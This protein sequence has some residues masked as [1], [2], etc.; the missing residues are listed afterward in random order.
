MHGGHEWRDNRV[1]GSVA[2]QSGL[3]EL[4]GTGT[5]AA[6]EN[7]F[8]GTL[9][10]TGFGT[11]DGEFVGKFFGPEAQELGGVF[12]ATFGEDA[13]A[14][15]F[16][17][18]KDEQVSAGT[19]ALADLTVPKELAGIRKDI[20]VTN[21]IEITFDPATGQYSVPFP[22]GGTDQALVFDAGDIDNNASDAARTFYSKAGDGGVE[23]YI[24]NASASNPELVLTYSTFAALQ[25]NYDGFLHEEI[26]FTFGQ[27]TPPAAIPRGGTATYSGFSIGQGKAPGIAYQGSIHGTTNLTANFG[28]WT[29]SAD[30]DFFADDG[31]NSFIG[32]FSSDGSIATNGFFSNEMRGYFYG[33]DADEFGAVFDFLRDDANGRTTLHGV[34]Y[35][36]KD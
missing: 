16:L 29:W 11:Y 22:D 8:G 32:S 24:F 12:S 10:I 15:S 17:G 21:L 34:T 31:Q 20:G 33:P 35:G 13:L 5:L 19:P 6:S 28:D 25:G 27:A 30:L 14:G 9:E 3:G 36:V 1:N 4:S 2:P 23:G 7:A 18:A 26:Y